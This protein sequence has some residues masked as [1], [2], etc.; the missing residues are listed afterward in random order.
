MSLEQEKKKLALLSNIKSNP[1]RNSV[2]LDGGLIYEL[3][4]IGYIN[5]QESTDDNTYKLTGYE[6]EY[7]QLKITDNGLTY[8]YELEQ[9]ISGRTSSKN[10]FEKLWWP[11]FIAI[12][13]AVAVTF[14]PK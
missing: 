8:L 10:R 3:C 2:G 6:H 13:T 4:C 11:L 9:S 1:E 5:G 12:T 7:A 14:I